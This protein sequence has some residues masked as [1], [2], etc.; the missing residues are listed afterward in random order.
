MAEQIRFY[1]DTHIAKAVAV[2]LRFRGVDIVR[3]EEV[4]MAEASD[5][6]H[7]EL[8]GRE[9]RTIVTADSDFTVLHSAWMAAGRQ[10]AGIV[11]VTRDSRHN[12]GGLIEYLEFLH[13]AIEGGAG[14]LENDV[15]NQIKYF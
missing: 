10:H 15:Y 2:Q 11:Y 5:A 9:G 4:G 3:C 6:A 1:T 14:T 8:A 7:L 12:I 13:L